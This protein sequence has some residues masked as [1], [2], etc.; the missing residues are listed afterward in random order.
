MHGQRI[1]LRVREAVAAAL[2]DIVQNKGDAVVEVF[3]LFGTGGREKRIRACTLDVGIKLQSVY[4][5]A[6]AMNLACVART[7][8]RT[9]KISAALHLKPDEVVIAA[10]SLGFP[11]KSI[12]DHLK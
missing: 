8:F 6:A 4:L 2:L 1:D 3:M 11:A 9:D 5:A 10:Q 12:L 7:G